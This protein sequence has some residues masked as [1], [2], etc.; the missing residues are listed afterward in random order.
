MKPALE[1]RTGTGTGPGPETDPD[2][3]AGGATSDAPGKVL[4]SPSK[5]DYVLALVRHRSRR[6]RWVVGSAR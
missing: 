6:Q 1:S 3:L 4:S 2:R 5:L